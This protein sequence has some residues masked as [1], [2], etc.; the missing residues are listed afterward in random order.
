VNL[1]FHGAAAIGLVLLIF[2]AIRLQKDRD[3]LRETLLLGAKAKSARKRL[4]VDWPANFIHRMCRAFGIPLSTCVNARTGEPRKIA[5]EEILH[6]Y[7]ECGF[8]GIA[9]EPDVSDTNAVHVTFVLGTSASSTSSICTQLEL[10]LGCKCSV[11][12]TSDSTD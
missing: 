8:T 7:L 10:A 6:V 12:F 3:F 5:A 9:I 11:K 2:I 4:V 1:I